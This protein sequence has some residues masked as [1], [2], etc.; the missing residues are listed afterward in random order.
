MTTIESYRLQ[1]LSKARKVLTWHVYY[2]QNPDNEIVAL[3][4][5]EE[6][7]LQHMVEEEHDNDDDEDLKV[8]GMRAVYIAILTKFCEIV[9][10]WIYLLRLS[11]S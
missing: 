2:T 6:A 9:S 7:F 8:K 1:A 10:D 5:D 3:N 4:T 11:A